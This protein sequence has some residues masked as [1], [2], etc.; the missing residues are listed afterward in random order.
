MRLDSARSALRTARL[1]AGAVTERERPGTPSLVLSQSV[2]A[3]T[4]V[5][6]GTVVALVVSKAPAA[7]TDTAT[8]TGKTPARRTDSTAASGPSRGTVRTHVATHPA[9]T[10]AIQP[11]K[12]AR[13]SGKEIPTRQAPARTLDWRIVLAILALLLAAA[14]A[15]VVRRGMRARRPSRTP[16]PAPATASAAHVRVGEGHGRTLAE[17]PPRIER[18]RVKLAVRIAEPAVPRAD[19]GETA[20]QPARVVVRPVPDGGGR[21]EAV[22]APETVLAGAAAVVRVE[23][24]EAELEID[25]GRSPILTRR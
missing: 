24:S 3:G 13:S 12:P 8:G 6:P 10:H 21:A 19:G 17:S 20:I 25:R 16:G 23:P 11:A 5:V 14:A 22:D 15:W 9:A 2:A 18:G 1:R 7:R 4:Q